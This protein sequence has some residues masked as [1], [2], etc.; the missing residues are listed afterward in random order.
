MDRPIALVTGASRG[1]GRAVTIQLASDGFYVIINYH[2]NKNAAEEVQRVIA[3]KGCESTV[4]QFDVSARK[5]VEATI[6]KLTKELGTI[7]VLVNNAGIMRDQPFI[8]MRPEDWDNIITTNLTGMYYC[9]RSVLKTWAGRKK[10]SRIVNITSIGGERGFSHSANYSASKAGVIGFTK[11]LAQELAPKNITVNAVSPGFIAT[12]GTSHLRAGQ[13]LPQIPLGR[14]G[15]PEDVAFVVSF[16][17]SEKASYI[18]GQVIR[19]NGGLY[20]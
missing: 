19:V 11:A 6:K 5:D 17:V 9:T 16:L 3:S 15:R 13:F 2:K 12:D 20:M 4:Q 8:R 1:I 14:I 10:G 7:E 18:T